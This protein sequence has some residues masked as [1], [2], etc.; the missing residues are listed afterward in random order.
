MAKQMAFYI[1]TSACTNCKTCQITCNDKQNNNVD[2]NW[3]RVFQYGGGSWITQS[4]FLI[5]SNVYAYNVSIS[6]MHCEEPIC[7]EVCPTGA[8]T[9]RSDGVVY[10]DQNKCIG[11]R[12]CEWACPYG[13][14]HFNGDSGTMTKCDFCRDLLDQG[15][16]PACV[17]ACIM[18]AIQF[19]ALEELR[20]KYGTTNAIE[21]LPKAEITYPAIIITPHKSAQVSGRGTGKITNVLEE[22]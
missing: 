19:G 20:V 22:V 21:P 4:N 8:T 12:Y 16:N 18:R 5:P 1:D 2:V 17:D 10:I 15:R 7:A 11:C 14:R 6:C 3:R 13:A 9:K